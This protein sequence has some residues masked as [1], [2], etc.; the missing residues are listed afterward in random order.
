MQQALKFMD[1][2]ALITGGSSGIGKAI[3]NE[4]GK[5]GWALLLVSKDADELEVCRKQFLGMGFQC[6]THCMDLARTEAAHELYHW[7]KGQKIS[8]DVLIN[9]AGI[10]VFGEVTE[11]SDNSFHSISILHQYTPVALCRLFGRDMV[12][13]KH[14][15]ILNVSS[16]SAVMPYPGISLYGPGKAFIRSFSRAL[17]HEMYAAGVKVCCVLPGAT[18]TSLYDPGRVNIKLARRLGVMQSAD[19]VALCSVNA[20]FRG[21]AESVPGFINLLM[22]KLLPGI[23]SGLIQW[24]YRHSGIIQRGKSALG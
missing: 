19:D 20:L 6:K 8:P 10:L 2:W 16:I 24:L 5:R 22:V 15:Y 4:L 23:P 13:N 14:G 3:A 1:K 12:S 18:E 21:S 11:V 7:C 17:R 9:N